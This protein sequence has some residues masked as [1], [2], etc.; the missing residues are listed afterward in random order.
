MERFPPYLL[1]KKPGNRP[2]SRAKNG[3][4]TSQADPR[5]T[6]WIERDGRKVQQVLRPTAHGEKWFDVEEAAA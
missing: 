4:D 1:E 2:R 3:E 6:Q 5:P